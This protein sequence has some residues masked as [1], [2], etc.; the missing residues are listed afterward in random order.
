[1]GLLS[2]RR[3]YHQWKNII[4]CET[5]FT[6]QLSTNQNN[7]QQ[8][9]YHQ[10]KTEQSTRPTKLYSSLFIPTPTHDQDPVM[11]SIHLPNTPQLLHHHHDL[12]QNITLTTHS[13]PC[14]I[15]LIK[16][17]INNM[18]YLKNNSKNNSV[19][20]KTTWRIK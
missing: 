17:L 12:C 13:K 20:S 15:N 18:K 1:M 6:S 5:I 10:T 8:D 11:T 19:E 14:L 2:A 7:F 16:Y 4:Q 9:S 3:Q